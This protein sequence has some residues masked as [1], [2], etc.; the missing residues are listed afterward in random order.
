MSVFE[1]LEKVELRVEENVVFYNGY[2]MLFKDKEGNEC[3]NSKSYRNH[4]IKIISSYKKE[5]EEDLKKYDLEKIYLLHSRKFELLTNELS[6]TFDSIE[7]NSDE[8]DQ[9]FNI[10]YCGFKSLQLSCIEECIKYLGVLCGKIEATPQIEDKPLS[11]DELLKQYFVNSTHKDCITTKELSELLDILPTSLTKYAREG[12]IVSAGK[13]KNSNV[14][15]INE[16]IRFIKQ[17]EK[18]SKLVRKKI[19]PKN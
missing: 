3:I 2:P 15:N 18:Y 19:T 14:Y 16:V 8:W 6:I 9:M 4:L 12:K 7:L 13:M 10:S 17:E 11:L 5:V 1:E